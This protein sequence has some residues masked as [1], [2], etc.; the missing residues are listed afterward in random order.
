MTVGY[1]IILSLTLF[2]CTPTP[3]IP[4]RF[5]ILPD[6][7][8]LPFMVAEAE[9][10]F[11]RE[12]VAVEL[13]PFV[14]AQERD[15]AIQAG[16]VDGAIADILAAAFLV[17]GGFD[18][19]VTSVSDG[20]YGIAAA[21]GSGITSAA[22]LRGRRVGMSTNTII[23]YSVDAILGA[24]GVPM[25]AYTAVAIPKIPVRMEML[26]AG[27]VDAAGLPEPLL[28]AALQRGATLVGTTDEF[29]ID[30]A[31][32]LFSKAI[33]DTRLNEVKKLYKAYAGATIR[34]DA[35]PDSYRSFLVEKAA[36]PIEVRDAYRF[37]VYRKPTL[38]DPSQI[39]TAL[40]WLDS[41]NLLSKKLSAGDIV[42]GRAVAG[43]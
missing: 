36:F 16:R 21:P 24:A 10:L 30:A 32:M 26:L 31:V 20:R 15:A 23:Q 13:V 25:D 12:G 2:C 43:W 6:A 27:Q 11:A 38:P 41:R 37:V 9:G 28:T 3:S 29:R 17:A 18:M 22:Q 1:I 7:D 39:E 40:A 34:I 35:N 5:G 19:R 8:S 14:N 33:L 4:L 42:D